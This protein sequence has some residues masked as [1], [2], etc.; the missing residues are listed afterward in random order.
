M[1]LEI[2]WPET[3][4]KKKPK[5]GLR[6]IDI[7]LAAGG[8]PLQQGFQYNNS[9]THKTNLW[10]CG[11]MLLPFTHYIHHTFFGE[12]NALFFKS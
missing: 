5:A 8:R 2:R 1:G 6:S 12:K 10:I 9:R 3:E 4:A 7:G 11:N